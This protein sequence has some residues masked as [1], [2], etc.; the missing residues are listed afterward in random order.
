MATTSSEARAASIA[1]YAE[2]GIATEEADSDKLPLNRAELFANIIAQ[3]RAELVAEDELGLLHGAVSVCVCVCGCS[4]VCVCVSL[5]VC[6]CVSVCACVSMS[7]CVCVSVSV[8]V[9]DYSS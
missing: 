1:P 4:T 3:S 6:I 2:R 8:P 9:P 5:S 7:V